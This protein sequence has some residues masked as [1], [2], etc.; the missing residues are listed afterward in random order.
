MNGCCEG[1][2]GGHDHRQQAASAPG[3]RSRLSP[4]A[5]RGGDIQVRSRCVTLLC[6]HTTPSPEA[7]STKEIRVRHGGKAEGIVNESSLEVGLK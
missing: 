6:F 2:R 1:W 5:R 4:Q 3:D 7:A